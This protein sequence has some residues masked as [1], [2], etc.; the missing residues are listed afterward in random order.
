MCH[1]SLKFLKPLMCIGSIAVLV[2]CA[3]SVQEPPDFNRIQLVTQGSIIAKDTL[4]RSLRA[5]A[6]LAT[7]FIPGVGGFV[8]RE[9]TNRRLSQVGEEI[10]VTMAN[11]L[12]N[13]VSRHLTCEI[14]ESGYELASTTNLPRG[15]AWLKQEDVEDVNDRESFYDYLQNNLGLNNSWS[16]DTSADAIL[17]VHYYMVFEDESVADYVDELEGEQ[18]VV[19]WFLVPT[20][21]T[22][23]LFYADSDDVTVGQ[24]YLEATSTLEVAEILDTLILTD[25]WPTLNF[26]PDPSCSARSYIYNEIVTNLDQES[27]REAVEEFLEKHDINYR[28]GSSG[29]T[30]IGT[31]DWEN[32]NRNIASEPAEV[33]IYIGAGR[34]GTFERFR[35]E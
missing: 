27:D 15:V 3:S 9:V 35:V 34:R 28:S 12:E 23:G 19:Y 20:D 29:Q 26:I 31:Y 6:D 14:R 5:A 10:Q 4:P 11:F 7:S 16:V 18:A 13:E 33:T 21:Q 8:A 32:S 25:S 30:L 22:S 24:N 2:S 1:L 17:F